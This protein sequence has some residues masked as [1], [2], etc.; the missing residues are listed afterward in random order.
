MEKTQHYFS[1][2]DRDDL[3]PLRGGRGDYVL[4]SSVD[5]RVEFERQ[6]KFT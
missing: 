3:K 6:R 2:V 5:Y 1:F 4:F